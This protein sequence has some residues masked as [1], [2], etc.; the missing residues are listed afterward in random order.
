M[1]VP[2]DRGVQALINYPVTD[3]KS[4]KEIRSGFIEFFA[5]HGHRF[6]PSAP[7]VPQDD[8]SLLF[9]NAGMN[10]FKSIFLGDN[11]KNLTRAA[12]SQKCMRVSGKHNDLEEV[13]RDHYHHTF[14][15]MLGNW[16]FGDYYKKEAIRW[17]WQ[18]LT[19]VWRLPKERLFV[20]IHVSDAE[21]EALWKSETDID[22]RRIMRFGDKSNFWEMGETGPCGPCSEVH[23]DTG[24]PSTREATFNDPVAGVNGTNDRYRELWNL[25]FI[26]YNREKDGLL[27]PL[28][29][30][31]VDT[32]MG[33]ERL[34]AVI[35]GVDSNYATDLFTP[36][37]NE[38]VRKCG[39]SYDHGVAG[40]P[41]RVIAD[42]VR[43]LIFAITDGAFPS[44][45]GRGYV[46]RRLLRRAYRFGREL[47]FR[48]PF[49]HTLVPVVVREM[50]EAFPEIG[51]R[52]SYVEEVIAAEEQRFGATLEQG[53]EKFSLMIDD[54]KKKETKVIAGNDVFTLY[55]T[56]GFPM[57][58]TRLMAAEQ[59]YAIDEGA[60]E[61]L[62]ERQKNRARDARKSDEGLSPEGWTERMRI[63]G[64]EFVG[65]ELESCTVNVC[66]FKT[67][68]E[69]WQGTHL[70]LVLDRTPF[71]AES[72]GQVGDRGVLYG[73]HGIEIRVEDT[74]KWNDLIVHRGVTRI[75]VTATAF[76]KPFTAVVAPELRSSTRRNHSATHLLQAA[77][78]KIL[79]DHI[80]QAGS[81]VEPSGLR[82][83]FTHFKALTDGEI[84]AVER[85]VNEW[86]VANLPVQTTLQEIEAAK[87]SGATALF[88][89]KYGERVRVVAMDPI[90]KELCG[91]THVASTGNIGLFHIIAETSISAGVRRIEAITGLNVAEYLARK[92]Q[93][94]SSL[95]SLLKVGEPKL[96]ERVHTL[97]DTVRQLEEQLKTLAAAQSASRL[98][99]LFEEAKRR[100]GAFPWL[101]KNL[102]EM[103]KE[104]FSRIADALSDTIRNRELTTTAIVLGASVDG[105]AL[106]AAGAGT[107][108]VKKYGV[109][110]G[111]L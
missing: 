62:M 86:I 69:D 76:E 109:H 92:E 39:K 37:I 43:A 61:T 90:S 78:R 24:D 7:V 52:G 85:Q 80:Q 27:T 17:G 16:S 101:A 66:R 63:S 75:P 34:C 65:Y 48:K 93:T 94:I 103:D 25:V 72:G 110:C 102:G 53:I 87:A 12:N 91:G 38:I 21:A 32:G 64:T 55:D 49:L 50:G 42:H 54:A 56:F 47:G 18:L 95:T 19:D 105:K 77:L 41:F 84:A 70:L 33:L 57:D 82:F 23:F 89:E 36:V 9:T 83:D 29:H 6:I 30:T 81:K 3:M 104:S 67:T 88:G 22:H 51:R 26:Q 40:T 96:V 46:L 71:Y 97:M 10:Q 100:D 5:A 35:Q 15:E 58:L 98:D 44:N 74:V 107:E 14:F 28:S 1:D 68:H 20:S 8:P 13:G 73:Q 59:G 99:D 106:F 108:A 45:E 60:Y 2:H 79:G 11:P 111:E 31:H 4:S